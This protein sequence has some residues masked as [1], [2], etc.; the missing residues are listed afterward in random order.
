MTDKDT[1]RDHLDDV[2]EE[3][4]RTRHELARARQVIDNFTATAH[5][6]AGEVEDYKAANEALLLKLAI[7]QAEVDGYL[8]RHNRD[9][10]LISELS[11]RLARRES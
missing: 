6:L 3:L 8:A 4:I 7:A 2:R 5:R 9:R 10:N 11:A 1:M